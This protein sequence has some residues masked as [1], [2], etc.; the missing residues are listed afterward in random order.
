MKA[1]ITFLLLAAFTLTAAAQ[2]AP[3]AKPAAPGGTGAPPAA[4]KPKP[5]SAGDTRIYLII[6]DGIQFQLNMSLRLRG[7]CKDGPADLLA[8][9]G[10]ISKDFTAL[11]TP[12]VDAAM[13]HGVEGKKIPQDMSKTDKAN[14]NKLGTIK[15]DKKWQLAFFD[16][17]AKESKKNAHEAE[18]AAKA[19]QDADLKAF[20]EKAV[21]LLKSEA[22]EI[23]AKF[24]EMKTR[25]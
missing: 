20:A 11:W 9:A 17:Y 18:N 4:A 1:L 7:K 23:E 5:Y 16:L 21:A 19:A 10:K 13:Q 14:L 12:G 24:K 6:A 2:P 8:L 15:D 3:G 25:K 22:E